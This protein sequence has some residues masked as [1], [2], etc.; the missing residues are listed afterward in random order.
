MGRAWM[1]LGMLLSA[2]TTSAQPPEGHWT[3]ATEWID[4]GIS[5]TAGRPTVQGGLDLA[6]EPGIYVGLWGSNVDFGDCCSE[7]LQSDWTLGIKRPWGP[8]EWDAGLTRS[9]FP[10]TSEDLD[11]TEYH[12]GI[13]WE[14]YG[15]AVA[16]TPDFGNLG[17]ELWYF[18]VDGAF[19]LPLPH[20][21]LLLHAGYSRGS[22]LR[23]RFADETRLEPYGDWQIALERSF[24]RFTATLAWAD[25]DMGGQF[26]NRDRVEHND[27]RLF[28]ALSQRIR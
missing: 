13:G 14:N 18:E 2:G 17:C 26:R 8:A 5:Q 27:G 11:S 10:G 15:V 28:F 24:G 25:T 12:V 6:T 3:V 19:A 7:Q 16:W 21:R 20:L 4:R 23:R 1:L 22:A 9:T